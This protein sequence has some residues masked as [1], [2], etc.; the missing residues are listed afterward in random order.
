MEAI[1]SSES[2][3][4]GARQVDDEPPLAKTPESLPSGEDARADLTEPMPGQS[5]LVSIPSNTH[6]NVNAG[7]RQYLNLSEPLEVRSAPSKTAVSQFNGRLPNLTADRRYW[8]GGNMN[9]SPK[10]L[11]LLAGMEAN[12]MHTVG[13]SNQLAASA[14]ELAERMRDTQRA[15]T[16]ALGELREDNARLTRQFL[17]MQRANH[18]TLHYVLQYTVQSIDAIRAALEENTNKLEGIQKGVSSV[19]E[20]VSSVKEQ[21]A[22]LKEG[23][24]PPK[25]GDGSEA[26]IL[27]RMLVKQR[28]P[29]NP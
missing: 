12:I 11:E 20:G 14:L 6:F 5:P 25:T 17:D 16:I 19:A 10:A 7:Y 13:N 27:R 22:A 26:S 4:Q 1:H 9:V 23:P 3:E 21:V 8:R 24:K 28:R 29:A 15:D 18:E 2:L